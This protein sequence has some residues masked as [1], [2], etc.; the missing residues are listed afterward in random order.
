ML[1]DTDGKSGGCRQRFMLQ[2]QC[3]VDMTICVDFEG[4]SPSADLGQCQNHGIH[5]A[6]INQWTDEIRLDMDGRNGWCTQEFFIL[7]EIELFTLY[8]DFQGDDGGD[9][10]GQCKVTGTSKAYS[11]YGTGTGVIGLDTDDR[12]GGCLQKFMLRRGTWSIQ[13][14]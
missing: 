2:S 5:C 9:A 12:P 10:N 4:D 11:E 13:A 1:I 8:M 14:F 3:T 6:G 7:S